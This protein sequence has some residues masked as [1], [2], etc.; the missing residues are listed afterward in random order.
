MKTYIEKAVRD[1]LPEDL[2]S[3]PKAWSRNPCDKGLMA[4]YEAALNKTDLLLE[5]EASRYG[6][7]C[8]G[9][10]FT[11]GFRPDVAMPIG[12]CGRCRTFPTAA[13]MRHLERILVYLGETHAGADR[14][15]AS[16]YA[17]QA[18]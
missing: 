8:G 15:D 14:R 2:D 5:A 3:Y 9:L 10:Q 11:T 12:V 18:A 16:R 1:H 6:T 7:L 4:D 17:D 13:M